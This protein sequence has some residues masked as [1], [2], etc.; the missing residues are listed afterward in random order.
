MTNEIATLASVIEDLRRRKRQRKQ[1]KRRR[2]RKVG[3]A[4][5]STTPS[6]M[7]TTTILFPA[8]SGSSAASFS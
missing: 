4:H 5:P 3:R 7:L 1:R 6:A 8:E 2:G